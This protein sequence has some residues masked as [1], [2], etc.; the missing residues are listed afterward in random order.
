ML[1]EKYGSGI[2]STSTGEGIG[3]I[4][5]HQHNGLFSV[6]AG[7]VKELTVT[8]TINVSNCV[9][10]MNIG[11]IASRNGGNVTLTK[12]IANE[13]INYNESIKITGTEAAGKNIGGYIGFV[14]TNGTVNIN[15]VSSIGAKFNL[16]GSHESWNVYGGAIGKITAGTFTV[17]IGTADDATNKLTDSLTTDITGI[18]AVGS[19]GDG[20]GLIGHITSAGSYASRQVNINN[21]AISSCAVGN[22]ASSTGGG[23]LGYSWLNTTTTI[24]GLTANETINNTAATK[25]AGNVGV[26]LYSSTGKMIVNSLAINGLTMSS[27]GGSS[28]GMIVNRAFVGETK[29]G[30][31]TYSGGLYLDVLNSGY[32]LTCTAPSSATGV[33]DEI[34]AY[35]AMNASEVIKGGAGVIS[36]N[37]N[38]G[39]HDPDANPADT[40]TETKVTVT[41]TYQNR[42]KI[43]NNCANPNSRYYY[44]VDNMSSSDA[45]QN[46][47]LW[48]LNKY[49][50]SG[51][52]DEFVTTF[53]TTLSGT[54]DM[55]GLSFY[56][57]ASANGNYSIGNLTL[58]FDYSGIYSTAETVS[59]GD[60]Y[61]RDPAVANQHYLMHSGLFIDQPSGNS[62]T[63]AGTLSLGVTFMEDGSHQ[64]VIISGTM[65]GTFLCDTGSII[66]DGI[67][68]M[69]GSAAYTSGYLLINNISRTDDLATPPS[70][71]IK[72]LSNTDKY[73]STTCSTY[74][75]SGTTDNVA[76]SLIGTASGK[77]F[78]IIFSKI[79]LDGRDKT[80]SDTNLNAEELYNANKTYNSIFSASTLLAEIN[81]DQSAKLEYNFTKADDWGTNSPREVTYGAEIKNSLDYVDEEQRYSPDTSGLHND[82]VNPVDSS[83]RTE[84]YNFTTAFLPYVKTSYNAN[85][86]ANGCFKR[87]LKVNVQSVSLSSGCGTYNDPY[88][89][90]DPKVF[91]AIATFITT[92]DTGD[93][94]EVVL[95]K[96]SDSAYIIS[97]NRWHSGADYHATFK[98]SGTNYISGS[99][100]W[101]GDNVRKYLAS[102]Y[103]EITADI[104]LTN[105]YVGLG[106]ASETDRTANGDYAFRGVIIGADVP[107]SDAE[108]AP[109]HKATITNGSTNP[110]INVSNGSVIKDLNIIVSTNI[111]LNQENAAYSNAFFGY[112][113]QCKYYG[114]I[115]GEVMGGDNI[116]DNSYVTYNNSTITLSGNNGT[117]VPVGGYV[118]VI[119]FG[120]V[121]F[122]NMTASKTTPAATNIR[123]IYTGKT[124]NLADNDKQ[125]DWAAIYANPIVGRVINGYAVNE[126]AQ[127]SVTENNKYHDDAKTARTGTL[128]TLKNGTKHYS[129]ADINKNETNWMLVRFLQA[130]L[131][132]ERS[133]YRIL[134]RSLFCHLSR[135]PVPEQLREQPEIM[136]IRSL[137]AHT[138]MFTV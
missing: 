81:T 18:T 24:D 72:N 61:I 13:T 2:T 73:S 31:T 56:P 126:T 44:N 103:Y 119:V 112:Y 138:Q 132:M 52:K 1:G 115:I 80:K 95:P 78:T 37:M 105:S 23:F 129:I 135:S 82:F 84:V 19:N 116:I 22:A 35:S 68:P 113:H 76:K 8:G 25:T 66:L 15:G 85:T 90:N 91:E 47:L 134:R 117:I 32:S 11:G 75:A 87:E 26:L 122:K 89:I 96:T 30:K 88:L 51:I 131:L 14:G 28:L 111:S 86:D 92:G 21:L 136:P 121:I 57:L 7:T 33:F 109:T 94:K 41:G 101:S 118:G 83:T 79:K 63:V 4:Y 107:D 104:E 38:G 133:I 62:L 125:E 53:N 97:G 71:T 6:L 120:V 69:S 12:V 20:G 123:V 106:W 114:G 93:L 36:I 98:A 43:G 64:G 48:S 77:G 34:A 70:V 137:M 10:G 110:F 55:T 49:A 127:F 5:R 17:N 59:N 50:Y 9:D 58:T 102:A 99:N 65:K 67:K 40:Y 128:H 3:Q 39:R 29:D 42:L 16:S 60:S 130:H 108:N 74:S 100:T 46:L 27:G 54:A 45:G 124:E